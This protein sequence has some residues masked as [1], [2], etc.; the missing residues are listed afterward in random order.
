MAVRIDLLLVER[1]LVESR[2]KAKAAIDAGNVT[3]DGVVIT[4]ASTKVAPD[5][6]IAAFPA[7]EYV[8]RAGLKLAHALERFNT[9]QISGKASLDIGASTGG[10]S[11]VLLRAG[12]SHVYAVDVGR[13][14]LHASLRNDPRITSLEATDA[15][16]LTAEIFSEPPQIVVCD[17]SFIA[18]EK[19]LSVP[20]ALADQ[21]ADFVGLF[22]PQFQVGR[23]NIGRGGIVRDID[24]VDAAWNEFENWL[25]SQD[26]TCR[27]RVDSPIRGGDGN[28][29]FLFHAQRSKS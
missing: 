27:A 5:A 13:D 4:R 28:R 16:H 11:D 1:G 17:A 12:A 6:D 3:V 15:R 10:F 14:Q 24:A 22:K 29:E 18:L 7:F 26:W 23:A 21:D 2:A 19:L 9:V 20:L 25:S 8:S